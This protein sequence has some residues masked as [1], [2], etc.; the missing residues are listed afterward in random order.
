MELR[1]RWK[2]QLQRNLSP[3]PCMSMCFKRDYSQL[4]AAGLNEI[5]FIDTKSGKIID[6]KQPHNSTV[7]CVRCSY[8]GSFFAS[9][10]AEGVVIIWRSFNN[11]AF[12]NYSGESS[13]KFLVW[14][15]TRRLLISTRTNE[16]NMWR[17]DDPR[18]T[19]TIVKDRIEGIAFAPS[20]DVFM[21]SFGSGVVQVVSTEQQEIVQTLNYSSVITTLS[22]A[23]IDQKDYIVLADLDR[24]VS[25][26]RASDKSLV[27]RNSLPF[28]ALCNTSLKGESFYLAFAGIGGKVSLLSS[29]LSYLGDFETGSEW[30]WDMDVDN[31]GKLAIATR[32]GFV[33]LKSI[34]FGMAFA[35]CGDVVT[36]RTSINAIS[37]Y[38]MVTKKSVELEFAKIIISVAMSAQNVLV[39]L[40]DSIIL[41]R[42]SEEQDNRIT[43]QKLQETPGAFEHTIFAISNAHVFGAAENVLSVFDIACHLEYT[44][45][46]QGNITSVQSLPGRCVLVSCADGCVYHVILD[47]KDPVLLVNHSSAVKCAHKSGLVLAMLDNNEKAVIYDGFAKKMIREHDNVVSFA[48]SDR[49]EDLYVTSSGTSLS[50]HYKDCAPCGCFVEGILVGFVQNKIILSNEGSL[51]VIDAPLPLQELISRGKWDDIDELTELGLM[52]EQWNFLAVEAAMARKIELAELA[53]SHTNTMLS[54]FMNQIAPDVDQDRWNVEIET[55]LGMIKHIELITEDGGDKA[56]ELEAAGVTE[57]ALEVYAAAGDWKNVL[58]LAKERHLERNIVNFAFPDEFAE[59]AARLLLDAGFGDGAIRILTKSQDIVSLAKAHVFLG[60]WAEAIS[61]S[62]LYSQVYDII[63]PK[64]GQVLF[65]SGKWFEAL[66]CLFIPVDRE[67]RRKTF[68][69]LFDVAADS[70]ACDRLAFIEFMYGLNDPGSYWQIH[71][72]VICYNAVHRLKKYLMMPLSQDDALTVFYLS[73]Y[74]MACIKSNQMRG[75]NVQNVLILLLTSSAILGFKRWISYSLKEL[76]TCDISISPVKNMIQLTV[77]VSKELQAKPNVVCLCPRC[78]KNIYE[79]SRIPVLA[80]SFCGLRVAFS[81]FTCK[82][83]PLTPF[84]YNEDNAIDL[85]EHEP[86]TEITHNFA[87]DPPTDAHIRDTPPERFIVQ[88]LKDTSGVLPRFWYNNDQINCMTCRT[89]GSLFSEEDYEN[90]VLDSES[91][92]ICRTPYVNDAT[93]MVVERHS[94]IL[95][96]LRTFEPA[97]PVCF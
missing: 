7:Y 87:T 55:F 4:I 18:A 73:Y 2:I 24:K 56:N 71:N 43:L 44:F 16:Y 60:Q 91:C 53:A 8:D 58:R 22:F 50:V 86:A 37:C 40:K 17:P 9:A 45:S 35:R 31:Y 26:F 79:S 90:S 77:K 62:R 61:L 32:E 65:E 95:E 42:Y 92:P 41:Y 66:V 28:E 12:V 54:F 81:A 48:F 23:T 88:R 29:G 52:D 21:L 75:I 80:C 89:C 69:I 97:S 47:Q 30:I 10:D 85:I 51:E 25:M 67:R 72:R 39:H 57:E 34:D 78:G 70:C 82:A 38:N 27:G 11:E 33:E 20:G 94:D 93:D 74:V 1:T 14:C 83:L 46:F 15:P 76:N 36:Y 13:A 84:E 3:I 68:D 64:F 19:R 59:Q 96:M 5:F 63:Y 6:Q 49:L